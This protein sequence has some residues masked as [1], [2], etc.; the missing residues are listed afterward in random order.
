MA[1]IS[2]QDWK[3]LREDVKGARSETVANGAQLVHLTTEVRGLKEHQAVTNA[4]VGALE[5]IEA[6]RTGVDKANAKL[7]AGAIAVAAVAI[8]GVQVVLR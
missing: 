5:V 4:R 1:E 8:A 2:K 7:V 3:E 6:V